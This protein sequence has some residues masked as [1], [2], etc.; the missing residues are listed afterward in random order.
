LQGGCIF[1]ADGHL[2]QLEVRQVGHSATI[3]N[4]TEIVATPCVCFVDL[5]PHRHAGLLWRTDHRQMSSPLRETQTQSRCA[6]VLQRVTFYCEQHL[7]ISCRIFPYLAFPCASSF[8]LGFLTNVRNLPVFWHPRSLL[9]HLWSGRIIPPLRALPS[10][11]LGD[12]TRS[13]C[14]FELVRIKASDA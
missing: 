10:L 4:R 11:S 14:E 1:Q 6:D 5:L 9:I 12:P 3:S 2:T 7:A 13:P 8:C